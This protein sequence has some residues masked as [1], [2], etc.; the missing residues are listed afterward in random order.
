MPIILMNTTK[1]KHYEHSNVSKWIEN[2]EIGIFLF[3]SLW[4]TVLI[5]YMHR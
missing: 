4:S 2:E 3:L 5:V 1:E